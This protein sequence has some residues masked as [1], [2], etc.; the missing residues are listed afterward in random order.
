MRYNH[1]CLQRGA[2]LLFLDIL[3]PRFG[4]I[5]YACASYKLAGGLSCPTADVLE[6][7]RPTEGAAP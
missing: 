1:S 7:R 3:G 4:L 5:V 2:T 6:G